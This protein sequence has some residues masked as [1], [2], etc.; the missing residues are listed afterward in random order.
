M[1]ISKPLAI[2]CKSPLGLVNATILI[3]LRFEVL[4]KVVHKKKKKVEEEDEIKK[5]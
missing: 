3:Q 1:P 2:L 5:R 4:E